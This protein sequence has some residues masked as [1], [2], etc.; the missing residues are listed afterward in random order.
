MLGLAVL[1]LALPAP[2]PPGLLD[3]L[4]AGAFADRE[5]AGQ[6]VLAHGPDALPVLHRAAR[7]HPDPEVRRRAAELVERIEKDAAA[8][9]RLAVPGVILDFDRL[10]LAAAVAELAGRTG[11]PAQLA[12]DVA[13]PGR[14]VTVRTGALPPW[15][16][17]EAFC[18]AA[19]LHERP[20]AELP[21]GRPAHEP[22]VRLRRASVV[23]PDAPGLVP[24]ILADGLAPVPADRRG[25]VR[26]Q[27]LPADFPGH[28]LLRG[29]G[30]VQLVLDV[31][32]LPVLAGGGRWEGVTAVRVTDA[33][34]ADGRPVWAAH[35]PPAPPSVTEVVAFGGLGVVPGLLAPP[36]GDPGAWPATKPNPRHASVALRTGDRPARRL[37]VLAGVVCGDVTLPDQPLVSVSDL[38]G[39]AGAGAGG[40]GDVRLAVLRYATDPA[41]R[42][43][44]R[45]RVDTPNPWTFP[46]ANRAAN[47]GFAPAFQMALFGPA[48]SPAAAYRFADAA[49]RTVHPTAVLPG[50]TTDDGL[51]QSTGLEFQFARRADTGPPVRLV[52]V[53]EQTVPVEVPFTLRDV[54]LP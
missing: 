14:P 6:T 36:F 15:E 10:P 48:A 27:A 40:G 33:A 42:T 2:P 18:R 21:A 46:R 3:G 54:P 19:G 5:R 45:V 34:D 29:A 38:A 28:R 22:V 1:A 44:V 39:A 35:P 32:P 17:V 25:G 47:V 23:H 51:R 49:G 9:A 8:A 31:A 13:D 16:A 52:L 26:V 4:G 41:G 37:G 53:G 30:V 11:V 50:E 7:S 24:V 12:A 20:R 43:V